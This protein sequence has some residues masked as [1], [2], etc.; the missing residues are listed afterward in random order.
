MNPSSSSFARIS[1]PER[2]R[3]EVIGCGL[4]TVTDSTPSDRRVRF[5]FQTSSPWNA[6]V[7]A[8]FGSHDSLGRCGD[9]LINKSTPSGIISTLP[10]SAASGRSRSYLE[11]VPRGECGAR[12]HGQIQEG[13]SSGQDMS[14]EKASEGKTLAPTILK[15]QPDHILSMSRIE[16]VLQGR[17][18]FASQRSL[19]PP[20]HSFCSSFAS[21]IST[22]A[23]G[24]LSCL[25]MVAI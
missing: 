8:S 12:A 15:L 13:H 16:T 25:R 9:D 7:A 11:L 1:S 3:S 5:Q 20:G 2:G 17:Q 22:S 6:R 18:N 21:L 19:S 10:C 4:V 24:R 14:Y 23:A